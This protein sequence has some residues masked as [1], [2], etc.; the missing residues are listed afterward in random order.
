MEGEI[1]ATIG[2]IS[3]R[4]HETMQ[5]LRGDIG[6]HR[7]EELAQEAVI[8][9]WQA[10]ERGVAIHDGYI[11]KAVQNKL[12]DEWR[13]KSFVLVSTSGPAKNEDGTKAKE[14]EIP[15]SITTEDAV[16]LRELRTE[17]HYA[18]ALLPDSYRGVILD[19]ALGFKKK[20]I[21]ERHGIPLGTVGSRIAYA[22]ERLRKLLREVAG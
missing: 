19:Y 20:E 11:R 3:A 22:K 8:G 6:R 9:M 2:E 4:T 7:A 10:Q 12:T 18:I 1:Y 5:R 15:D 14:F 13:R 21:A 16:L 17:V